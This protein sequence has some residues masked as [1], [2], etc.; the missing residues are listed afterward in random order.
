M[1]TAVRDG[2]PSG[3]EIPVPDQRVEGSE[4][5]SDPFALGL[6]LDR[7]TTPALADLHARW[8]K[9]PRP[10]AYT[11]LNYAENVLVVHRESVAGYT[12]SST[13]YKVRACAER[14]GACQAE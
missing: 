6:P 3:K 5:P 12:L 4:P 10:D 7:L 9:A 14:S 8:R 2:E 13:L 1:A 11:R